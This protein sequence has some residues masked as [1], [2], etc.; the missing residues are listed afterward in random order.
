MLVLVLVYLILVLVAAGRDPTGWP[1]G[2]AEV[3]HD[4]RF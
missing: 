2:T 4:A 3:Q 1:G